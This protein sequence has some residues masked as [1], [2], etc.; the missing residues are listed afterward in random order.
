MSYVLDTKL[1]QAEKN[2]VMELLKNKMV[3]N[4]NDKKT[5]TAQAN[6]VIYNDDTIKKGD[7]FLT[8]YNNWNKKHDRIRVQFY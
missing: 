5:I 3:V 4:W 8:I 7:L 2:V 1:S 6:I